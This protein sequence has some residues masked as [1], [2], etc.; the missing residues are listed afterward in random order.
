MTI[1][2]LIADDDFETRQMLRY[3]LA[4]PAREIV[5][6][7]MDGAQ[8]VELYEELRP[9]VVVMDVLMPHVD[10]MAALKRIITKYPEARIV[11]YTALNQREVAEDAMHLGAAGYFVKPFSMQDM[12]AVVDAAAAPAKTFRA[13]SPPVD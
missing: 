3:M 5:G 6:E 7:A 4:S 9:D 11:V 8:A 13:P 2:I 10:G 1:C 12:R